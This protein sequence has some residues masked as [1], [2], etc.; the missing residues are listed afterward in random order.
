MTV[1]GRPDYDRAHPDY[2]SYAGRFA[3]VRRAFA[4]GERGAEID[5][6]AVNGGAWRLACLFGGFTRPIERMDKRG[7]VIEDETARMSSIFPKASGQAVST[8]RPA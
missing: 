1:L 5:L 7:A 4:A 2:G 8:T 6:A 3:E